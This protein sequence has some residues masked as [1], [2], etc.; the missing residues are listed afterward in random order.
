[1]VEQG[2]GA[3]L[4][5]KED[6]RYMRGRGEY[7]ADIKLAGMNDVAFLRSPLAHARISNI[8]KPDGY[9]DR[10]FTAK[11]LLDVKPIRS[12]SGL[13]GFKVSEQSVLAVGKVRHVGE[14]IAMCIGDTR[15]EAEDITEQIEV[16]FEELPAVVD[17][18]AARESGSA[19][20]HE[21]WSDNIYLETV[22]DG[23]ISSVAEKA[24]IKVMR[25]LR[26]ARQCMVPIEGRGVVASWDTRLEQL[27]VYSATQMPHIVRT[28]LSDCLGMDQGQIRR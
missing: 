25:E 22:I 5:R 9:S 3:R 23:D 7:V 17:M 14:L 26:T 13:P 11:D 6:E 28:G 1:M 27:L 16:E 19:L 24:A 8:R 18:R 2:V 4:L 21:E 10:I 12:V 20:V 15:A